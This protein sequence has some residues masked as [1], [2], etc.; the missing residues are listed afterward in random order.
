MDA[1]Q[2]LVWQREG[3]KPISE[4]VLAELLWSST[5]FVQSMGTYGLEWD[6]YLYTIPTL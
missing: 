4:W 5:G 1:Y 6:D 2:K 3:D